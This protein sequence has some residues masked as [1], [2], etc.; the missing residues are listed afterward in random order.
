MTALA[1]YQ[2]DSSHVENISEHASIAARL[3]EAG[4]LLEQWPT[5]ALSDDADQ[6]TVLAA[7][8]DSIAKLKQQYNF[9]SVDVVSLNADNPKKTEFR[10]MFLSEHTHAD[11]EIRFFVDGSGLFYLHI[12]DKVYV[13]L[14][15][16]GDLI[17]VPANTTHW[18]DMGENPYFKC[19]RFFT[20]EEG[21]VA[22][23][24]GSDIALRFPSYDNF[25]K[26]VL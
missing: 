8:Q 4:V 7:Y 25:V 15:T 22:S 18:F 16:K 23:F 10:N 13:L 17:S 2:E 1:I 5:A 3:S 21:W 19:I 12:G 26:Q 14:C 11:F 6:D 20:T 9:S 24:T